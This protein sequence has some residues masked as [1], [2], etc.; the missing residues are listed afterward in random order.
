ME[1]ITDFCNQSNL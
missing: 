1:I